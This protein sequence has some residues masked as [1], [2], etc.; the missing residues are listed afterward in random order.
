MPR[1]TTALTPEQVKQQ[2]RDQGITITQWAEQRGYKR[3]HV[4]GVLNGQL[5]AHYGR[6][7]EIAVELGL[8]PS[9]TSAERNNQSRRAA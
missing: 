1:V 6:A 2:L 5:K 3:K 7:H 9:T 8:K 4:Y